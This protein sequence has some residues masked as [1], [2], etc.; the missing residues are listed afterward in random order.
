MTHSKVREG[1]VCVLINELMPGLVKIGFTTENPDQYAI[2]VS[3]H[4]SLPSPFLVAGHVST[5]DPDIVELRI[6]N[7][8]D[9][10]RIS[11]NFFKV[12]VDD[13][14]NIV[15]KHSIAL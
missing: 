1:I 10:L 3:Q 13:A 11:E 9:N 14:L 5:L 4:Y 15:R 8:L 7:E 2:N 6:H 12:N